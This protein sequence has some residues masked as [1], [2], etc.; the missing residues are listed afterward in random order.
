MLMMMVVVIVMMMM[1]INK[2]EN[3]KLSRGEGYYVLRH[4]EAFST[5][6]LVGL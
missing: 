3:T 4:R 1:M 6:L 5:K 2:L